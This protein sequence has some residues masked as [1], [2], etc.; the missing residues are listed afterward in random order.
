MAL[1]TPDRITT[2][3]WLDAA[4]SNTLTLNGSNVSQWDDKSGNNYEFTQGTSTVQPAYTTTQ[5]SL[6][7]VDFDQDYLQSTAASSIWKWLHDATTKYTFV[8]VIKPKD[9]N[10]RIIWGTNTG[11]TSTVGANLRREGTEGLASRAVSYWVT[12]GSNDYRVLKYTDA[13]A[14]A[15]NTW[16]IVTLDS[17]LANA[18]ISDR[19]L[20]TADGQAAGDNNFSTTNQSASTA[21]PSETLRIG[22]NSTNSAPFV[23]EMAELVFLDYEATT[24]TVQ[25]IEGYLAWKWGLEANLPSGHP[26]KDAAP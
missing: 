20:I 8:G 21:N 3:L 18:T 9:S 1:W 26:Y 17:D 12:R 5:N 6:N 25:K 19:G 11:S 13:D 22:S 10:N 23:G 16:G 24:D 2:A 14:V 15:D 7:T 4:D